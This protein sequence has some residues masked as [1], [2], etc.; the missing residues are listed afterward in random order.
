VDAEL[1]ERATFDRG[2][3]DMARPPF[4]Q[5]DGI[6]A[7]RPPVPTGVAA[8]DTTNLQAAIT[9]NTG[10]RVVISGG[11]YSV[12]GLTVPDDTTVVMQGATLTEARTTGTGGT[13]LLR[14]GAT[15]RGGT[16]VGNRAAGH[17]GPAIE[18]GTRSSVADVTISQAGAAGILARL[19]TDYSIANCDIRD[20]DGQGISL[21]VADR[22]RIQSC[23][24]DSAQ[25]GIQ[26]WGG[27]SASSS[28]IGMADVTIVGCTV[29][30]VIGGIWGSL[31]T[32]V[33]VSG[34]IVDTCSDVGIDFEGC[35]YSTTTGCVVRNA[36]NAGLAVFHGSSFITFSSCVVSQDTAA[37]AFKAFGTPGSTVPSSS[38]SV[39]ACTLSSGGTVVHTDQQAMVRSRITSC[40]LVSTSTT[41]TAVRLLDCDGIGFLGNEV[42]TSY[43]VGVS[44][45]G[46]S[47]C[48]VLDNRITCT[49]T[50]SSAVAAGGAIQLV[51]RSASYPAQRNQVRGNYALGF[52][53]GIREDNWGDNAAH[54]SLVGN[55][56]PNYAYH[57]SPGSTY[58][59]YVSDNRQVDPASAAVGVAY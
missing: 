10:G 26:W 4:R 20:C 19:V 51:W 31:G 52:V 13:L 34:C 28:T 15:L 45:E 59:S 49:A 55:I 16:I 3:L 8:T 40:A 23:H 47:C 48:Q 39:N 9:A 25:H 18:M 1:V 43:L 54:N 36:A 46:S 50:D 38:I 22:G 2:D 5:Q 56:I 21:D 27:D 35:S 24:V 37:P 7:L 32:R 58:L 14:T 12:N 6:G 30:N 57:G 41:E 44:I 53:T 29:R 42:A 11:D 17:D 33:T